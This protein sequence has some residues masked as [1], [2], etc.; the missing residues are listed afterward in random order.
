[1][2]VDTLLVGNNRTNAYQSFIDTVVAEVIE[3]TGFDPYTTPMIIYTTM[4]REKQ[5]HIDNVMNN[6]RC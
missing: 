6:E 3:D 4:D 1:M 5:E 2:P